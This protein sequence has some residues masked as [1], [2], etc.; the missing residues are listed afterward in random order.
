MESTNVT[1]IEVD[2]EKWE[3][4]LKMEAQAKLSARRA[5]VKNLIFIEKAKTAGIT[6]S[7]AEVDAKIAAEDSQ[8]A[9]EAATPTQD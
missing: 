8:K 4:L 1:K 2:V 3:K 7:K 6:V 9:L 5:S